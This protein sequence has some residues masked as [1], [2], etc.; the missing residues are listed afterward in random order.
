MTS[1]YGR[2]LHGSPLTVPSDTACCPV[3]PL[4]SEPGFIIDSFALITDRT[5]MQPRLAGFILA[6]SYGPLA[7]AQTPPPVLAPIPELHADG[8]PAIPV[9]IRDRT[10]AYTEFQPTYG[11]GWH[12]TRNELLVARR[13]IN[14][15]Q[16]HAVGAAGAPPRPL[17]ALPEPVRF[18]LYLAAA[19][20]RLIFTS[21]RG[22][23]E[24]TQVYAL[25][26]G[27]PAPVALTRGTRR[28]SMRAITSAR[29]RLL[30]S[31]TALDRSGK[32]DDPT[33]DLLLLDPAAPDTTKPIATLP[34][35]GWGS[36][37]FAP[38]DK[39]IAMVEYKSVN[40]SYV[41]VMDL[42]SGTRTRVFPPPGT[43]AAPIATGDLAYSSDGRGLFMATDRDGEF[44]RL[45]YLDLRS[46]K[47]DYFGVASADTESIALSPD[48]ATLA[49]ITNE[50]GAGVLRLYDAATRRTIPLPAMPEG[51]VSRPV[52]SEDSRRLAVTINSARSPGDVYVVD[53]KGTRLVRWTDSADPATDHSRFRDATPM[54]WTSFDGLG[55]NGF[56]T[57]PPPT[58]AGRRPVVI[59]IHGGPEGQSRPGFL[60]RWN[61][62]VNELGIAVLAPNVRGSTGYGKHFVALDNGRK[63]EDSVRDIGALLDWIAT[64]PDLDPTRVAVA[65]GSYGG[66]MVLAVAT[67]YPERIAGV[68]DVVGIANFVSFLENTES[69]RRDLRRVEYG[70]E[71]DPA[72]RAFL[73]SISPVTH[74]DKIRAPLFVVHG[75]N[76]PRVPYTEAEQIVRA[77]RKN[78]ARVWYLLA[79]NEG[80]GYARKTNADFLFYATV[81]FLEET[82]LKR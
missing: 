66:Y 38:D 4:Q 79:D 40:E 71:R 18:G 49:V 5:L 25:G 27:S 12:P 22:G 29:D 36:F 10:A 31:S 54:A 57:R 63:R 64:Q 43:S 17:T 37:D 48:R 34:G 78:G 60:G 51:Q 41:W 67:L 1:R 24:E 52:W 74:A 62:V 30:I 42:P 15:T 47:L 55:L 11:V 45:A 68:I 77:A 13:S 50:A 59:Q 2:S 33:L 19:P 6:L 7:A 16:L 20:D 65:G 80:H 82:L 61:Y 72:M 32:Q 9:A 56:I 76:D 8:M 26:P 14:T 70:D 53:V 46:G 69:Y 58:F 23:N 44:A 28:H 39:R 21:D 75:R 3:A 73:T 35:T 81:A